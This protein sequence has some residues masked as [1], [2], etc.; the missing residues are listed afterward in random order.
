MKRLFLI[1]VCLLL[2]TSSVFLVASASSTLY[3]SK[4]PTDIFVDTGETFRISLVAVGD[5]LKY[6][7]FYRSASSTA[8]SSYSGKYAAIENTGTNWFNG[9]AFKCVITDSSGNSVTSRVAHVYVGENILTVYVT[10][11]L[12]AVLEWIASV[13]NALVSPDGAL[14]PLIGVL[15]IG[16]A[17][18]AL[19]LGV[20]AIR[21]FGWGF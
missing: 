20:K 3:I 8:W 9:C 4:Q 21:S 18:C 13:C 6:E 11:G 7:W 14:F 2:L 10:Q 19:L 17:V 12:S 5:G 15:A 1:F 16:I